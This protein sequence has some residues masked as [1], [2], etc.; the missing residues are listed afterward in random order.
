VTTEE[1]RRPQESEAE[2]LDRNLAE[3]VNELRVALPGVQVLFAFLLT[4]PFS[5]R[6]ADL[7]RT[8]EKIYYGT[9]LCTAVA[10]AFLIAPSAHHRIQFRSRDK[11]HIVLTANKFAIIGLSFLA[12][13][14][15]GAV[16]LVTDFIF[17]TAAA[18]ITAAA[19]A[20][21]FGW[22]WYVMPLLRRWRRN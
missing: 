21:L 14:M 9:L 13:A 17:S 5:Q 12:L 2:R 4:V 18:T 11:R 1:K 7:T 10:T 16:L 8:Q 19:A 20:L 22:L 6:F 15:T 3:L